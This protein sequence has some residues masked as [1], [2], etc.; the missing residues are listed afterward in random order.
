MF[1][2]NCGFIFLFGLLLEAR[3]SHVP[4]HI[5]NTDTFLRELYQLQLPGDVI[6]VTVDVKSLYTMI[7]QDEGIGALLDVC[8]EIRKACCLGQTHP[9][10]HLNPELICW[11]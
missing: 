2:A 10:Q 3:I 7:P 5:G 11:G 6:L 8:A 9:L 1:W 4:A